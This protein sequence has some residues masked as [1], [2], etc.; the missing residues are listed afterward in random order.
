MDVKLD[1]GGVVIDPSLSV[2]DDIAYYYNGTSYI[3]ASTIPA[4][5]GAFIFVK[6]SGVKMLFPY[7]ESVKSSFKPLN[8]MA[9]SSSA[10]NW[11]VHL[12]L[13]ANGL[14]DDGNFAGV[15][16]DAEV[17][18]DDYDMSEP[19]PAPNGS[20]LAFRLPEEEFS[21]LRRSDIR[22]PFTD[23]AEWRFEV[24]P[25]TSRAIIVGGLDRVPPGMR[26]VIVL[27][28]GGVVKLADNCRIELGDNVVSG[29]L[30]IG[31]EL[32]L[33]GTVG[34]ILPKEFALDQNYPN[35]FNPAT[36]INFALPSPQHVTLTVF[37]ILGQRVKT[38]VDEDLQAGQYSRTWDGDDHQ[39]HPAASGIY[40]YR[41]DA[42]EF[43][44]SRK[45]VLLK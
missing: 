1:T 28:D 12:R 43:S 44:R 26:A 14:I 6:R 37:N 2:I 7:E 11:S 42:G 21:R 31:T 9:K 29:T 25:G 18:S 20:Y 27:S 3:D 30:I 40:F 34:D 5:D 4:W 32:Y 15:Q 23:G 24:S 38:I 17:G 22:P 39:G 16:P 10:E 19:P 33:T 35:P 41:L 13:E 45:M 8:Q 36:T